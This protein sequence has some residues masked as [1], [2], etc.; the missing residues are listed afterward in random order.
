[1]DEIE[2]QQNWQT[3]LKSFHKTHPNSVYLGQQFGV[4][5]LHSFQTLEH[6]G[7][8]GSAQQKGIIWQADGQR[9]GEG[10][11]EGAKER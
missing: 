4:I 9:Q 6:G 7:H 2:T 3:L 11:K 10:H 5:L 1:M 8:M